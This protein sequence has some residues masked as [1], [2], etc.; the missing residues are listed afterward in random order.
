MLF[1]VWRGFRARPLARGR[2]QA[3]TRQTVQRVTGTRCRGRNWRAVSSQ[4]VYVCL[5]ECPESLLDYMTPA[6]TSCGTRAHRC[7][8]R[9]ERTRSSSLRRS[10]TSIS[11]L[12]CVS[13]LTSCLDCRPKRQMRWTPH[14]AK[15][16]A[17]GTMR[18]PSQ[19]RPSRSDE[20]EATVY[21][22]VYIDN[23][24]ASLPIEAKK[25]TQAE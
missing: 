16:L 18:Q 14:Y 6:L 24:E 8:L 23:Y 2:T 3:Q 11:A 7:R 25:Q 10:S 17:K 20:I 19:A 12:P 21:Q 1:R 22:S 4:Q 5:P 15:R 13:M 9:P